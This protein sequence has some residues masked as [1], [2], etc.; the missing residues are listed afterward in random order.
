MT[1][2]MHAAAPSGGM[3]LKSLVLRD[4]RNYR[5]F[6]MTGIGP[7]TILVGPNAVGKTS[8]IE[9]I[10]LLSACSSFRTSQAS[11]MIRWGAES[12]HLEAQFE[13][14]GRLVDVGLS[15]DGGRR[16]YRLNGKARKAADVRGIAPS[17]SFTPDD[18]HLA[19]G[20][21]SARRDA[22]DGVG[23]QL[24]RNFYSVCADYRKL[25]KQKNHALKDELPDEYIASLNDVLVRVGVQV[26][27]HRLQVLDRIRP[28]FQKY[29][30][31]ITG[32][33]EAA[34]VTYAPCW[35]KESPIQS[36]DVSRDEA[37]TRLSGYMESRAA[38]ER[39][40]KRCLVG[41]H[42]DI[43]TFAIEGHDA[44][45]FAS[46]GQ[47]RSLVL[48]WKLAEAAVIASATGS[49]PL[50]LL[51]DVMS[52]LDDAR[53]SYFMSFIAE[54]AQAFITTTHTDYFT[55]EMLARADIITLDGSSTFLGGARED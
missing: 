8:A 11:Q 48:A 18:L 25:V 19:K 24:S 41:P 37:I 27:T 42:A 12:A 22:I 31:E 50:L 51:D 6:E 44:S 1:E 13:G 43:V 34:D 5:S 39:G 49:A 46:Q 32:G 38:A 29:Y 55:S 9:G 21:P 10:N 3:R 16:S 47:Q 15:I 52:E 4:F 17:V 23:V 7:L 54:D 36:V 53:R 20:A 14:N 2:S 45:Q 28:F 40:Q 35:A 26:L 33:G 30:L